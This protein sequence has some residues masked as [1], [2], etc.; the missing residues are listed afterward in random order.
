M[1]QQAW[2]GSWR[3]RSCKVLFG[4][5]FSVGTY[6]KRQM[7]VGRGGQAQSALKKELPGCVVEQV[8]ATHN[9]GHPLVGIIHDDGQLI[10]KKPVTTP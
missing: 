3:Q 6:G 4:E 2:V 8:G 1:P 10:G 9:V 7:H 5:L